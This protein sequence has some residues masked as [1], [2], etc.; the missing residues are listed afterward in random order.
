LLGAFWGAS[1]KKLQMRFFSPQ[2]CFLGESW[3]GFGGWPGNQYKERGP[4]RAAGLWASFPPVGVRQSLTIPERV[5]R[6]GE[7]RLR[8]PA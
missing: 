5:M 8:W 6:P 1:D 7:H 3:G 4:F 2:R